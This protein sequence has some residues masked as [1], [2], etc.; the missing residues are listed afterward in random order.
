MPGPVLLYLVRHGLAAD[1]GPEYPDD[2]LRPLT[3]EG[4]QRSREIG[5]GLR[6][7]GAQ[8]QEILTS[9]ATRTH[10]TAEALA[11]AWS[12][13]PRVADLPALGVDGSVPGVLDALAAL[14]RRRE[15]ALVGHAPDIGLLAARLIGARLPLEFKKGAVCCIEVASLPASRG[16]LRWFL[17][18]RLLRQLA[19]A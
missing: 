14:A 15:V 19:R 3:P 10:Q 12:P 16:T 18:P 8:I 13:A 11:R 4:L 9:P 17:P 1:R 2:R 5:E 7:A 6:A